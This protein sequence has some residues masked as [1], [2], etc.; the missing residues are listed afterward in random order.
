M[1]TAFLL[2]INQ[3]DTNSHGNQLTV[4][5]FG[6]LAAVEVV[7]FKWVAWSSATRRES[8]LPIPRSPLTKNLF[9]RFS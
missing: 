3:S 5:P 6:V 8:S 7:K 2:E 4:V 1:A 9:A